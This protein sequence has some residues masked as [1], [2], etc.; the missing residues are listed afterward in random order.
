MAAARRAQ[1]RKALGGG[2]EVRLGVGGDIQQGEQL[3]D[4]LGLEPG[5]F[6]AQF[7][8]RGF[9]VGDAA[10]LDAQRGAAAA[11]LRVQG[12]V[13]VLDGLAGFGEGGVELR[14][15]GDAGDTFSS[16]RLPSGL[17]M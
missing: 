6:D 5:A 4:F 11:G 1:Q 16:S 9:H 10:E 12:G 7:V 2:G 17:A 14:A 15:V 3:E 8:H 13:Q